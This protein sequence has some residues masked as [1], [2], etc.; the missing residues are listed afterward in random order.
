[1]RKG[2]GSR[3][4]VPPCLYSSGSP[5][6]VFFFTERVIV[7]LVYVTATVNETFHADL[8]NKASRKYEAFDR[9]FQEQMELLYKNIP[10]Y[11]ELRIVSIRE[12]SIVVEHM[13]LLEVYFANYTEQYAEAVERLNETLRNAICTAERQHNETLCLVQNPAKIKTKLIDLT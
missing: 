3:R 13:V 12:G 1:M 2:A 4:K 10:S 6:F 5:L 11:K 9:R 7:A 8:S